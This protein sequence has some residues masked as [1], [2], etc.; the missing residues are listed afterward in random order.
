MK[1]FNNVSMI[2][3]FVLVMLLSACGPAQPSDEVQVAV[4]VALTQTAAALENPA[5]PVE[6]VETPQP[7]GDFQP[8]AA[9]ECTNLKDTLSQMVGLPGEVV[10]SVPFNDFVN[11]KSGFGCQIAYSVSGENEPP[12]VRAILPSLGWQEN[13]AYAAGGIGGMATAYQ[14]GEALCLYFSEVKPADENACP[15]GEGYI[16][17]AM[18]LPPEQ[19]LRTVSLNCARPVP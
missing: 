13:D 5:P 4:I 12:D 1:N 17:C 3:L 15:T 6:I 8:L 16:L 18:E 10:S 11:E 9:D 19:L 14:N 2:V 7:S